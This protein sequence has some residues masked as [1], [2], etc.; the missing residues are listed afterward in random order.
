MSSP[1]T[2]AAAAGAEGFVTDIDGPVHWVRWG[3]PSA[4]PDLPPIVF[5]HGLGGSHLD[6]T[7]V[8]PALAE[9]RVAYALDLRG[10]GLTPS[11]RQGSSR[12]EENARLV[13]RFISIVV[14]RPARVVGHGMGGLV[15]LLATHAFPTRVHSLVL[16]A[17]TLPHTKTQAGPGIAR[18]HAWY[19]PGGIGER[20]ARRGHAKT[21]AK[22]TV[23]HLVDRVFADPARIPAEV[24]ARAGELLRLRTSGSQ[25]FGDI[26]RDYFVAA[27][28]VHRVLRGRREFAMTLQEVDAPV[29]I[30]HA[31]E[32]RVIPVSASRSVAKRH[33]HWTYVELPRG[34]HMPHLE[35]PDLVIDIVDDWWAAG[36]A[37]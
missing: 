14:G 25:T 37:I 28:S 36:S 15:A 35:D 6:W 20:V 21:S 29:L 26:D 1:W 8:G 30:L 4:A 3:E 24:A 34:G 12:V 16:L 7:E 18:E 5:V 31:R 11:G 10:F 17:P 9:D 33:L 2:L 32:D 23:Q 27:R 19:T 22:V 13:A